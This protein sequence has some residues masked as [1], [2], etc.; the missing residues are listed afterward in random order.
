[1]YQIVEDTDDFGFAVEIGEGG[2]RVDAPIAAGI[3]TPMEIKNAK[4]LPFGEEYVYKADAPGMIALD[5]E[6][7]IKLFPGDEARFVIQRSGPWRVRPREALKMAAQ[8]GM[9]KR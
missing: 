2:E 3:L 7:E 1:V 6:R 8:T 5:G 9:F 4:K